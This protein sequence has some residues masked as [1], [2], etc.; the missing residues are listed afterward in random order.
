MKIEHFGER[1]IFNRSNIILI[2]PVLRDC[3]LRCAIVQSKQHGVWSQ[4]T[5]Q[6]TRDWLSCQV[7]YM[8]HQQ[9]I[10]VGKVG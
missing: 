5:T 9:D 8:G 4:H 7:Q 10:S 6:E 3:E 2:R 1:T